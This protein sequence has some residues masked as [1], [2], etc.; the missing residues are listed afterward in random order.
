LCVD[1]LGTS[2]FQMCSTYSNY[3]CG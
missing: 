3:Y 2:E 1:A